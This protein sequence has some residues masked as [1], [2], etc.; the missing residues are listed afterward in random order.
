MQT[1]QLAMPPR[2]GCIRNDMP[3]SLRENDMVRSLREPEET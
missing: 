3:R 2:R 1:R